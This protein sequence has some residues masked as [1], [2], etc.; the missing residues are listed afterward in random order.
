VATDELGHLRTFQANDRIRV[1]E[2]GE[3]GRR[4][5]FLRPG[6]LELELQE[7]GTLILAVVE[8]AARAD[9][10]VGRFPAERRFCD[11]ERRLTDRLSLSFFHPA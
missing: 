7:A 5:T 10:W 11:T 3:R 9:G 4:C 1:E 2:L 8:K 6:E